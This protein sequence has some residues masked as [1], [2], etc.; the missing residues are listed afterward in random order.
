M[1]QAAHQRQLSEEQGLV[2]ER[3]HCEQALAFALACIW[4]HFKLRSCPMRGAARCMIQQGLVVF[5]KLFRR[6]WGQQGLS[7]LVACSTHHT[8]SQ[9]LRCSLND[10]DNCIQANQYYKVRLVLA[11]AY[12]A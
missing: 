4:P 5:M 1:Q 8:D 6:Q 12:S 9:V 10:A 3:L 11:E 7:L 2:C